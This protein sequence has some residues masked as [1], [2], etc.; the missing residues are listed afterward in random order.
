MG[1]DKGWGRGDMQG[2]IGEGGRGDIQGIRGEGG[3]GDM[4]REE[5]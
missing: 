5:R 3:R 1:D 4:E 2:I